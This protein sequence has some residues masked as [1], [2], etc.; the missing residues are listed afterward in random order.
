[1]S[2]RRKLEFGSIVEVLLP[3]SRFA[4]AQ[5]LVTCSEMV[6]SLVCFKASTLR[7][8]PQRA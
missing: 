5:T 4:Y 8:F 7:R 1:M 6:T 2:P 3:S